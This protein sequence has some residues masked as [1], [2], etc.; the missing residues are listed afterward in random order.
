M[1]PQTL[2]IAIVLSLTPLCVAAAQPNV[3]KTYVVAETGAEVDIPVSIFSDDAGKPDGGRG[4]RFLTSDRR[5]NLTIQSISN[6]ANDAPANFLAK[7]R[8]P[9]DIIYRKVTSRFFV[10][11]SILNDKIWYNRCNRVG[12]DMHCVLI[13]YPVSEKRQWDDVVTRIS[14]SL[15]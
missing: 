3:W 9:S 2:Y 12:G 10:V 8:P 11:S 7:Q 1:T 15:K 14:K 4:Q 13:N 5:A 6:K